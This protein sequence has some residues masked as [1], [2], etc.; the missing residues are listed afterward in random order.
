MNDVV[1]G[2]HGVVNV[3]L[4]KRWLREEGPALIG[5]RISS[6]SQYDERSMLLQF[7][8]EDGPR[9]LLASVLEEFPAL[10][11]VDDPE[12]LSEHSA[13]ESNFVKAVNFHLAG[14]QLDSISQAGFDRS[15]V[16]HFSSRDIYGRET[17]KLLRIELVS[18]ASNAFIISDRDMVISIFKRVRHHQNRV[19]R[20][21]TGKPLPAPP[22]LGK[23]IAAESSPDDLA[24]ELAD[25]A[26]R[27]GV[28]DPDSIKSFFTHRVACCDMRLWREVENLLPV[29]Y[30]LNT[31]HDFIVALQRGDLTARLFDLKAKGDANTVT[32]G[33]WETARRKRGMKSRQPDQARRKVANRL[34][35]LLQQRRQAERADEVEQLALEMLRRS[36]EVDGDEAAGAY[37]RGWR[38]THPD[39]AAQVSLDRSAYDNAQELVH[40]AQRLRRGR[41]KLNELIKRTE[42][43]LVKAE[44]ARKSGPRRPKPERKVDPVRQQQRRLERD[45]VKYHRFR[46]SDGFHILCGINDRSNDGLIRV[47][48]S[49]RHLW[50]HVR[51][52]PGSHVIIL[53]AGQQVPPRTLEEAALVAAHHSQG[54]KETDLEVSY[55]PMKQLRRPRGGKPGQ[56]LKMS[57]KVITVR[58]AEFEALKQRLSYDGGDRPSS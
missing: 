55:L 38:E 53:N 36:G 23:Y 18:R 48:G 2:Y 54:R 35:Q 51:D 13:E 11:M 22:E 43:E 9:Y 4:L 10:F 25:L 56:V 45:G 37:L 28:E 46:S 24:G 30:D 17:V 12:G 40:Y 15:V 20:I 27:D 7:A 41:D 21:I 34:D 44:Q 42:A 33:L 47:F 19:R 50:L 57:E 49:G 58:P 8:C 26:G 29:E 32:R 39:F 3:L 31:L 6:A 52:Y 5:C 1:S 16:F 14:Y